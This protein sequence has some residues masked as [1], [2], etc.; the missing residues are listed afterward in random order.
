[1]SPAVTIPVEHNDVRVL[2]PESAVVSPAS[3]G[4]Q[5]GGVCDLQIGPPAR[6]GPALM[7]ASWGDEGGCRAGCHRMGH[8][9]GEHRLICVPV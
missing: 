7:I 4:A 9:R 1:M 2:T 8:I 3:C 6:A 5:A